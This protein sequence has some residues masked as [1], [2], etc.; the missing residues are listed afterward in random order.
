MLKRKIEDYLKMWQKKCRRK[1]LV[2]RGVR[3]VGKS[4]LVLSFALKNKLKFNEINLERYLYLDSEES[5]IAI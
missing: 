2:M 5:N 3:Q 4:T 1:P